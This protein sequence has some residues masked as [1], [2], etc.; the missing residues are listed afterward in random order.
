E[1]TR[2]PGLGPKTAVMLHAEAGIDSVEALKAALDAG[3]LVG[4]PGL[5]A[6]AV[7][8]LKAALARMGAKDTDRVPAADAIALAEEICA[9]LRARDDVVDVTFTGSLR[10]MRETIGD[11]DILVAAEGDAAPI[12]EAFRTLDLV[13]EV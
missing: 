5:G 1:L 2:I 12:H 11:L 6:K 9:R 3:S 4:L 8:N 7:A 13:R 10:R